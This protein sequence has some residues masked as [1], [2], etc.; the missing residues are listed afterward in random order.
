LFLPLELYGPLGSAGE[1]LGRSR[2]PSLLRAHAQGSAVKLV[3]YGESGFERPGLI[4]AGGALRDLSGHIA[5]V[6][7][8]S[9]GPKSLE[10]IR[11]VPIEELPRVAGPARLG[12]CVGGVRTFIC[13]GLN[14]VDHAR[15]SG[16]AV[17][18]EPILFMKATSAITGATGPIVIPPG[19]TKVDWEVELGAVIGSLARNVNEHDA[20]DYVAGYLVVNDLSERRWQLEG[21]GQWVKGKSADSFA[22]IGPWLVTRDEI[23]DP[24]ALDLWL[25]VNGQM[26]QQSRTAQM[27]FPVKKLVSYI[28]TFMTLHPGDIISTGTPPGVGMGMKPPT[29]LRSGD[30][31]RLG[32]QGLGEQCQ[33]VV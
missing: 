1:S 10:Q 3:R 30:V 2:R 29:Y 28:S 6:T 5:D 22:P 17:P 31:V 21:T 23:P 9:L 25:S 18:A 19:A 20:L 33:M 14:Y 13:V 32:I 27:I 15:E 11:G 16:A 4:D 24:Q 8:A 12:P 26:R 7:G